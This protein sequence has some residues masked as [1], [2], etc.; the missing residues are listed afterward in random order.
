MRNRLQDTTTMATDTA[1]DVTFTIVD[2]PAV[3]LDPIPQPRRHYWQLPLFV[4][5]VAAAIAAWRVFPPLPDNPSDLFQ[6]DLVALK[7]AV[8]RKPLDANAIAEAGRKVE[9]GYEQYPAE[10]NQAHFL[11]GS[12][13]AILAEAG[14]DSAENWK[15][16]AGYFAK[17]DALKLADKADQ[18]RCVF[19]SAKAT[20]AIGAGNPVALLPA[21]QAVPTGDDIGERSRLIAE[22][23]LRLNPPDYKRAKEEFSAFLSGPQ[24]S[25]PGLVA[26]YRLKLSEL[27]LLTNE[28]EK[29]RAWLQQIDKNAAPDV[30]ALAKVQLARLAAADNNWKEAVG[31]FAA[32]QATPGLPNDQLGV[33]RYETGKGY[34]AL[35]NKVEA[36]AFF[37]RA[38]AEGGSASV[39][40]SMKLAELATRDPMAKGKRTVAAEQLEAVVKDLKP[41]LE[42]QNA[43]VSLDDV[44]NT[45]EETIQV[46]LTEGDYASALRGIAAYRAVALPGRDRERKAECY[47]AWATALAGQSTPDAAQVAKEK[48][49]L[50]GDEYTAL[51][52]GHP[53]PLAKVDLYRRAASCLRSSGDDRAALEQLDQLVLVSGITPDQTA[54]AFLERGDILL[55]QKKFAEGVDA[56]KKVIV[57]SGPTATVAQVKLARAH[58]DEGRRKSATPASA[59]EGKGL[60]E[61]GKNL[62]TQ[63]ANKTY[64]TPVER[65]AQQEA[66]YDLGKALMPQNLLEAE[67][68]FRQL[69]DS[70]PGGVFAERTKLYLGSCLLLLARGENKGG[71]PPADA[72]RKL[73]EALGIFEALALS[74]TPFMQS[75]A[76]IRIVNAT[77]LLK[78]Y[79][80]MPK[81]CN[82]TAERYKNKPEELIVL[83][84]LYGSYLRSDQPA[85]ATRTVA[86]MEDTF[87]AM[88]E[89]AFIG[90]M[91]EFTKGYWQKWFEELKRR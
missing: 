44:R 85:L 33:I 24:R 4:V 7:Q 69:L 21:L 67:A 26:K 22:T 8:D 63:V 54:P 61:L 51:A 47:G 48:W 66:L 72:E 59:S 25:A 32:A 49:K 84:M 20:A 10:A 35:N 73:T 6:R 76:D 3:R 9:S 45:F 1:P 58:L 15:R 40:S 65:E 62:L 77:L 70:N 34:L 68:R 87:G 30:Q 18:G 52:I 82:A 36:A 14:T 50:A 46:C 16:S 28:P 81:L 19:R 60:V 53:I 86:R 31:L 2:S 37:E 75:Q 55:G 29:A 71:M 43:H 5:G 57:G 64:E 38:A 80:D 39:A 83:K 78:K 12:V 11:L 74:K 89:A 42:F 88:P 79:D 90:G 27:C 41:G 56:L 23:C 13:H 91:E 17:C